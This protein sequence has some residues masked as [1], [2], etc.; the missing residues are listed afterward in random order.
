MTHASWP[1]STLQIDPYVDESPARTG[2]DDY[3]AR[4]GTM[5]QQRYEELARAFVID[6]SGGARPAL[7][8]GMGK[9]SA[10]A[11]RRVPAAKA[12]RADTRC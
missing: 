7:R 9:T 11:Q 6:L 5:P 1:H 4:G 12:R 10:G 2:Y 3:L 8:K